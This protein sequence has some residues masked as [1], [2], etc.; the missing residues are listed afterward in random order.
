[1]LVTF[2]ENIEA[3]ESYFRSYSEFIDQVEVNGELTY[4]INSAQFSDQESIPFKVFRNSNYGFACYCSKKADA[5]KSLG[6]ALIQTIGSCSA[7]VP[8]SFYLKSKKH[9]DSYSRNGYAEIIPAVQ[10][11]AKNIS[12]SLRDFGVNV[13]KFR[14]TSDKLI[15]LSLDSLSFADLIADVEFTRFLCYSLFSSE[16]CHIHIPR[17]YSKELNISFSFLKKIKANE[18]KKIQKISQAQIVDNIVSLVGLQSNLSI[19]EEIINVVSQ[20]SP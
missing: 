3:S 10:N 11:T 2:F 13:K 6:T 7:D 14:V 1:M 5:I 20:V 8:I 12:L 9:D 17:S 15:I 4:V 19:Q 18:K 16:E